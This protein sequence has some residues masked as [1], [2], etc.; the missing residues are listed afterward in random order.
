VAELTTGA[1]TG[2]LTLLQGQTLAQIRRHHPASLVRAYVD[3]N[4]AGMQWLTDFADSADV[5]YTRRTDH[6]YATSP[7]GFE[8]AASVSAA[9]REAGLPV[10][11][12]AAGDMSTTPFPAVGA[13]ALDDQVTI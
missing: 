6:S 5:G 7:E 11:M 12:L 4:R 8:S 13:V 9:A 2:K 10:R 1:N 3:A